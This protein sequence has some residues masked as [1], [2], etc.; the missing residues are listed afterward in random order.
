MYAMKHWLMYIFK[1][2]T[3]ALYLKIHI[4][5]TITPLKH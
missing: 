4:K 2:P 1:N 3:H 5:N